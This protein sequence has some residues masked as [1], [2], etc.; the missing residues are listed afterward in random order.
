MSNP[1]RIGIIGS[2]GMARHHM[3]ILKDMPDAVIT[4]ITEPSQDQRNHTLERFPHLQSA[5]FF[6]DH[7]AMLE[8]AELDA[9]VIVSPHT[10]H[11]PQAMDSLDKGLHV[12]LEKP[13]VCSVE[14]ADA[15]ISKMKTTGKV[16]L[17]G[18][19]RHYEPVFRYM[20]NGIRSGEIGEVQFIQAIN[21]QG[22]YRG[23]KGSWRQDPALS[24][25]G[26]LNDTGSHLVD[27]LLWLMGERAKSVS[28][29]MENFEAP[30]D[31]NSA[32]SI[33]FA[34]GAIGNLSIIGNAFTWHE[35]MTVGGSK[36]MYFLRNGH[37]QVCNEKGERHT[38]D[39]L[40]EGSQPIVNFIRA[41]QGHEP[42]YS[43]PESARG[44]IELTEAAWKS[45][46]QG[47]APVS[48]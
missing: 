25:G 26:Q 38:P 24:G 19:Q 33:Q 8:S 9:V 28:A 1:V 43:T 35:D 12:M 15:F 44:V 45:A 22:W 6:N 40:P 23:T 39:Q 34:N 48:V 16:G 36:G 11:F 30:V 3:N 2:G 29:Y 17:V 5:A 41:I 18:Y 47:G 42:V 7:K 10:L 13:F 32:L 27:V 21:C 31:I 14:H 37:F 20:Y 46:A 4:A